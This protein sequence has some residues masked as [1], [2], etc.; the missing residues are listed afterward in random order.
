MI[1][2]ESRSTEEESRSAKVLLFPSCEAAKI[3][4]GERDTSR[5]AEGGVRCVERRA[6][7][8]RCD[9][10][11]CVTGIRGEWRDAETVR[12]TV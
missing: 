5:S 2:S 11:E 1:V 4:N 8:G 10:S 6:E 9:A 12:G 3:E 7:T